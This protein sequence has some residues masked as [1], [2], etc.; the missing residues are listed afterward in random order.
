M[1]INMNNIKKYMALGLATVCMAFSFAASSEAA[2]HNNGH[3]AGHAASIHNQ[4]RQAPEIKHDKNDAIFFRH[5]A[6]LHHKVCRDMKHSK[7]AQHFHCD[8][9]HHKHAESRDL[10]RYDHCHDKHPFGR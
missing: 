8:K 9:P 6:P 10:C 4:H 1:T 2:P 5:K 7:W 3:Q